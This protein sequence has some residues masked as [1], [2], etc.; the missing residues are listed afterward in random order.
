[1]SGKT[2]LQQSAAAQIIIAFYMTYEVEHV[3]LGSYAE[4]AIASTTMWGYKTSLQI[5]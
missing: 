3:S 1:M 4:V 5:P 2:L